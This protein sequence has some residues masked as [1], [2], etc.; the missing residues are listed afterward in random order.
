VLVQ[1]WESGRKERFRKVTL[2]M[3]GLMLAGALPPVLLVAALSP[4]VMALYGPGFREGW[5][6]LVLLV[7]AA[8][9]HALSKIASGALLGMNRAWW[10]LGV[11]LLWGIT[12]LTLTVWLTPVWGVRGLA[13]AFLAAYSVL[14]S[15]SVTM[16]LFGSRSAIHELPG[17][18]V[19]EG[20]T[21]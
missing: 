21:A 2:W 11:N 16:V 13:T 9:F 7:A 18:V 15:A 3:C 12:M 1:E 6:I 8:P 10:V 5:L 14:G 4:W 19:N 17:L 20:E